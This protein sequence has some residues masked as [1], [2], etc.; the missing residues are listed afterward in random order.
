MK[1]LQTFKIE[2]ASLAQWNRASALKDYSKYN[3]MEP[4]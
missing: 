3:Q 2:Y 4:L 1:Y